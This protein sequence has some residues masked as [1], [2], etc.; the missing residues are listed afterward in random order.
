MTEDIRPAPFDTIGKE[1]E[2]ESTKRDK[3][4]FIT[5]ARP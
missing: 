5:I 4:Y 1:L 3:K 2:N